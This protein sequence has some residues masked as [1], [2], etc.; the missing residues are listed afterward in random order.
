M[1]EDFPRSR[2]GWDREAVRDH[3]REVETEMEAIAAS[4]RM[5]GRAAEGVRR[6]VHAAEQTLAELAGEAQRELER[7]AVEAEGIRAAARKE[8][9]SRLRDAGADDRAA[10]LEAETARHAAAE[11]LA[12]ARRRAAAILDEADREAAARVGEADRAVGGFVAEAHAMGERL[13][14]FGNELE[15]GRADRRNG[16]RGTD[17]SGAALTAPAPRGRRFEPGTTGGSIPPAPIDADGA[18]AAAPPVLL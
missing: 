4:T 9:A 1:R 13:G 10:A 8:A 6:V 16:N 12:D 7:A 18:P 14:A 11:I 17:G 15:R 3:L 2:R 5:S